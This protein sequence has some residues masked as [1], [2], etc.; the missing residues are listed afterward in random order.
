MA[1]MLLESGNG[2]VAVPPT[3]QALLA[4]RLDQLDPAERT[5]L[6]RAAVEGEIFHH[7]AVQALTPGELRLTARL[8]SL[9]R[10]ELVRREKAQL[11]GEDGFRFRHLLIRDAAY[12]SLPKATRGELHERFSDWLEAH[13]RD[14][15][16]LDEVIGYHLERAYRYGA[17]LGQADA[18]TGVLGDR[19]AERLAAAGRRASGRWDVRAAIALLERAASLF[20]KDDP[21]RLELLPE[22]G[23]DLAG[24]QE[25]ARA[26]AILSEAIEA[27]AR[28]GD[29]RTEAH[30]RLASLQ[31]Q[32]RR[33]PE[34]MSAKTQEVARQA[35]QTFEE[36]GDERGLARAWETLGVAHGDYDMSAYQEA[37]AR[38]LSHA[39][40][41]GD[42]KEEAHVRIIY[43]LAVL[44]GP[45]PL[46]E[47]ARYQQE[48]LQW[49]RVNHSPRIEAASLV[50]GGRL[51]AMR[52][53]FDD[54]RALIAGGRALFKELGIRMALVAV[55]GWSGEVEELAGDLASAEAE[56]RSAFEVCQ[57]TGD[58]QR[59]AEL[60]CSLAR[61]ADLQGL[62]EEAE[63]LIV[64]CEESA[65]SDDRLLG[66]RRR[67]GRARV[68]ARQGRAEEA[69]RLAQEAVA[70]APPPDAV[71]DRCAVLMDAAAVL[72]LAGSFDQAAAIAE[73]AMQLYEQKGNLVAAEKARAL[74]TELRETAS[75]TL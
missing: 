59:S 26:E 33:N 24:A 12:D 65:P 71:L 44:D 22:L 51:Q 3:I 19:A 64:I 63:R 1:A 18:E 7:G 15:V 35:I 58:R 11:V 62:Y 53:D 42:A 2:A 69:A 73:E 8:T 36:F 45:A 16:E 17:E 6:E 67:C 57:Q 60:A 13:G 70:L 5:V 37:L 55:A 47:V 28:A 14:L 46:V 21:R 43:G 38:A 41:A 66:A 56:F 30:A 4:A 75:S 49:A 72:S 25:L 40:K 29:S 48:N 61:L 34:G 10:K 32:A 74:L 31:V 9:V 52:G 50:L 27:A 23:R 20:A 68:L 54:A 39:G